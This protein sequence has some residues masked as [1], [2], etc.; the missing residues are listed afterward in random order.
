M[1]QA[2]WLPSC[3]VHYWGDIDT[4]GFWILDQLRTVVPHAESLLMNRDTLMKH[5]PFWGTEQS[6]FRRDLCRLTP[7]ENELFDDLRDNRIAPNLR[8]EQQRIR[9]GEVQ[10]T[11]EAITNSPTTQA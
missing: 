6:P 1:G 9:F 11:M 2:S 8:L 4:H 10:R 5:Q 3:P 7:A